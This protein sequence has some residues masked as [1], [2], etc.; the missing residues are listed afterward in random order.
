M[1]LVQQLTSFSRHF[2]KSIHS[3]AQRVEHAIFL[4]PICHKKVHVSFRWTALH[5][6]SGRQRLILRAQILP[7]ILRLTYFSVPTLQCNFPMQ[8]AFIAYQNCLSMS[9]VLLCIVY[10]GTAVYPSC[11]CICAL[12]SAVSC[13]K[14]SILSYLLFTKPALYNLQCII[15]ILALHFL[16]STLYP[17]PMTG[18]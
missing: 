17:S 14:H 7:R 15:R 13:S 5:V 9:C 10:H 16:Y 3:L 6:K 18:G 8:P 11:L 4:S 12:Y 1:E 2:P